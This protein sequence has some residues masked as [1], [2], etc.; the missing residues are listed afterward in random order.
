MS[1]VSLNRFRRDVIAYPTLRSPGEGGG[2]SYGSLPGQQRRE[3]GR[4]KRN[5]GGWRFHS[6]EYE[7]TPTFQWKTGTC[8]AQTGGRNAAGRK[9]GHRGH[10]RAEL[11][12]H[13]LHGDSLDGGAGPHGLSAAAS[14]IALTGRSNSFPPA[15]PEPE[16]RSPNLKRAERVLPS[17]MGEMLFT[18]FQAFWCCLRPPHGG[19]PRRTSASIGSE[20]SP[21]EQLDAHVLRELDASGKR[22]LRTNIA[23]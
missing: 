22:Q 6:A 14:L 17:D 16:K 5:C 19:A 9:P 20:V 2:A 4:W 8:A 12:F 21:A 13:R 23:C 11:S 18:H 3:L 15:G 10:R 7:G 1:N